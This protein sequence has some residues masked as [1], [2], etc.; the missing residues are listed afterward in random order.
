MNTPN[1]AKW[2]AA[3]LLMVTATA[4]AHAQSTNNADAEI[5]AL[6]RQVL[7][8]EQKFDKL[9]KQTATN[10][11]AAKAN[12][13]PN[14]KASVASANAAI[15]VKSPV[16]SSGAIITMPNNRPTV[17]TADNLNC[18]ALT[19]RLNFDAGG[20]DY[21]PNTALTSPQQAQDG[22]NA[23][24]ARL[25]VLGTFMGEWDYGLIYEFGGPQDGKPTLLNAYLTYKGIKDLYIDGGYIDVPYT[26]DEA[27]GSNNS[28]FME[29]SSAQSIAKAIAAGNRRAALGAHADGDWWWVGSYVTGP[30]SG[31]DHSTP[32]PVGATARGLIVPVNNQY[33]SLLLGADAEFLF[34]TGGAAG[35]NTLSALRDRIELRI[36]PGTNAL[37]NTGALANVGGAQVFSGEAAGQTGSFYAQGEY[38]DYRINRLG[39]LPDLHFNGGYAQASYTLTGEH[40]KYDPVTGAYGGI[41]PNNPFNWS[42]GGW[43]A[44]EIA[45]RYTQVR[46]NDLDI[47]GGEMRNITVGLNW[48]VNSNIRFMFNWIHG[49]VAKNTAAPANTDIG[50]HYDA[51]AMRTQVAF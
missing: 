12:A 36:D 21:R 20:Y 37:L 16:V 39:G 3:T 14:S 40:R 48:Y 1:R 13:K 25:G 34:D 46:L 8:L 47:L 42:A 18:V 30:T 44:W 22:V 23:R 35:P 2:L 51:F 15:P 9:Q 31:F 27:T 19:S 7:A 4:Q 6:K 17:C 33:G 41:K 26:L 24:R 49:S 43:G 10:V 38:F 11:A 50:A 29:R 28:M 5:A 32:P 45:A